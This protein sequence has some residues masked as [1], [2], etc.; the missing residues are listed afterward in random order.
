MAHPWE[1]SIRLGIVH[2]MAC[3]EVMG[4]SGPVAATA[5]A[6]LA[7]GFFT[8]LEAGP[9]TDPAARAALK[10]TVAARG[11]T[12]ACGAQ[13]LQL[14]QKLNLN[15]TDSVE[16]GKAVFAVRAELARAKEMDPAGFVVLSGPDPADPIR[17]LAMDALVDSLATICREA[18]PLPVHLEVFDFDVDKKCLIGPTA[19]A[20]EL[21]RRVR[22][23]SANFGLLLDL[24]HLPIQ[25]EPSADALPL[26]ADVL[27]HAHVGN[28][29]IK[30]RT[31]PRYGDQH[32][33]FGIAG[34]ENGEAEL[35]EFL[36]LLFKVGYLKRG[37]PRIVTI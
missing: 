24:S 30:D 12:L 33:R 2:F 34:G 5:D 36:S 14:A 13:P 19:R 32:P 27:T 4:G 8:V 11:A 7:D 20:V 3:P 6:L 25:H 23:T 21:A 10:T 31:H 18:A 15:A 28:C 26:A 9:V 37:T 16:R 29:V 17:P 22:A 1:D 35:A